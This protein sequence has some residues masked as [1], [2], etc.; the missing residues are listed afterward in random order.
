MTESLPPGS[1]GSLRN[2]R[3]F[4]SNRPVDDSLLKQILGLATLAPSPIDLQPWRFLVVRRLENRRKLRR[5]VFG[6]PRITEAPIV[7]IVLAYLHPDRTDLPELIDRLLKEGGIIP[8]TAA[9]LRATATRDWERGDPKLR[10]IR[11]AMLA[12]GT[13][14]LAAESLGLG[15]CW[16]EGFDDETVREAFGIP[17]DHA[18]CGLIALGHATEVAPFPGRF[19][20]DRVC[21]AEHFGLPW[22]SKPADD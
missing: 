21:F 14:M 8:E 16:L 20:L 7:L 18:L 5:S 17:D 9:R 10:S 1:I 13:L 19:D 22:P 2:P 4:D 6:D 12:S 15:S 3:R 11:A